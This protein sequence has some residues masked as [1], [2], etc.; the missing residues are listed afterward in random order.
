MDAPRSLFASRKTLKASLFLKMCACPSAQA[1]AQCQRYVAH[2]WVPAFR[3]DDENG[4]S[5]VESV[6]RFH[7]R[8]GLAE[9][10]L[11]GFLAHRRADLRIDLLRLLIGADRRRPRLD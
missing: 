11:L 1:G 7:H 6:L 8:R 2:R 5:R 10:H 9:E 4:D 3:G